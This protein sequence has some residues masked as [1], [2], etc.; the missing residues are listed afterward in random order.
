M[1]EKI[2]ACMRKKIAIYHNLPPGGGLETIEEF[3]KRLASKYVLDLYTPHAVPV[4]NTYFRKKYVYDVNTVSV[5]KGGP[6]L[7]LQEDYTLFKIIFSLH[8]KIP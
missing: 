5:I 4:E 8:K 6:L 7:R 2:N 3:S 1:Q